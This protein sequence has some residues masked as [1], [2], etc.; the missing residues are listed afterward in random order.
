MPN[1]LSGRHA[2]SPIAGR[3]LFASTR[4]HPWC[5]SLVF[6][7]TTKTPL[8]GA[9]YTPAVRT[10]GMATSVQY[11]VPLHKRHTS[12]CY[13]HAA[14][15]TWLLTMLIG[16]PQTRHATS[17]CHEMDKG[18]LGLETF[19]TRASFWFVLPYLALAICALNAG[20][21]TRL[22]ALAML[23][24][25]HHLSVVP[26]ETTPVQESTGCRCVTASHTPTPSQHTRVST[27]S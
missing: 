11:C 18:V 17:R 9:V 4:M 12:T 10:A 26:H 2:Q 27:A 14:M 13:T 21:C 7:Q 24:W 25:P 16:E 3:A 20:T 23:A 22:N 1:V 6:M 5:S 15:Q 8:C 19:R